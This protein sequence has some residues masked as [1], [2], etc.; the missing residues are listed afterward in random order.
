M[1]DSTQPG[2]MP[3]T[4][5]RFLSAGD[6]AIIVEFGSTVDEAIS[7]RVMAMDARIAE[8]GIDGIVETVPT[9]RSLLVA[10]D[11]LVIR[12]RRLIPRLAEIAAKAGEAATTGRRWVIPVCYG[13]DHGEDLEWVA[14]VHAMTPEE[15]IAVHS[16]TVYRVYMIGFTPGFAYLGG[17]PKILHTPRRETPRTL[18]PAGSVAIGGQ[19]AAVFSVAAP[20]GWHMLGRTPVRTFD[21]RRDDPFL[22]APGDTIRFSPVAPAEFDALETRAAAGDAVAWREEAD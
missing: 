22:I 3:G 6:G 17:L 7:Q 15:A 21:L 19:Q 1:S 9:Y 20:S 4:T 12:A 13:G 14:N 10:Y 16:G 2:P 5:P 8:A 11:P 18:V